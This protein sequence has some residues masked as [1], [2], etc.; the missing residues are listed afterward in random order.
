M[1]SFRARGAASDHN[2]SPPTRWQSSCVR[3]KTECFAF[4]PH[5][6]VS[7]HLCSSRLYRSD[8]FCCLCERCWR[9][10]CRVDVL[11]AGHFL[12][13]FRVLHSRGGSIS[14]IRT[15]DGEKQWFVSEDE[16]EFSYLP[17]IH[18]SPDETYALMVQNRGSTHIGVHIF[19]IAPKSLKLTKIYSPY[20]TAK[21]MICSYFSIADE[22]HHF[23]LEFVT[24]SIASDSVLL[25]AKGSRAGKSGLGRF[26]FSVEIPSGHCN[27]A[28]GFELHNKKSL[29]P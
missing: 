19:K 23:E 9:C 20:N 18:I 15:T 17:E 13:S 16:R 4:T 25:T 29:K 2:V 28:T 12:L 21:R 3:T 6:P 22:F 24:W 14:Y 26:I 1:R 7:S 8:V 27:P 10:Q 11:T 5:E